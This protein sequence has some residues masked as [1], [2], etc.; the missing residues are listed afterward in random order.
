MAIAKLRTA[1]VEYI[2]KEDRELA[3]DLQT[4]FKLKTLSA[5]EAASLQDSMM[6]QKNYSANLLE[7]IR[8]ALKGWDNL[9]DADGKL[10]KYVS[11]K[12][13]GKWLD[14]NFDVLA[15][16]WLMELGSEILKQTYPDEMADAEEGDLK[17][18]D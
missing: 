18:S 17:N 8:M 4:T 12:K 14:Q 2:L 9:K 11:E 10:V 13:T 3:E 7:A 16:S 15:Q 1:I 6:E 5:T